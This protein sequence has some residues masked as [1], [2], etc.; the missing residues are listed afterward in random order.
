[1]TDFN[2]ESI[3]NYLFMAQTNEEFFERYRDCS[4]GM[5]WT[6][7]QTLLVHNYV[8]D[9]VSVGQ[10]VIAYLFSSSPIR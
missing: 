7:E 4:K 6:P 8:R 9:G 10:R 5:P 3:V 1:M 2:L